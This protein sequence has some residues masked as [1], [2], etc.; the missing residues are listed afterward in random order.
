MSLH[1]NGKDRLATETGAVEQKPMMCLETTSTPPGINKQQ[2]GGLQ[3]KC[4]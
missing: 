3:G 1:H 4:G 2:L